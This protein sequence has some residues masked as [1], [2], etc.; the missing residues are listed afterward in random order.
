MRNPHATITVTAVPLHKRARA[1]A[2]AW[3][4]PSSHISPCWRA[5]PLCK[6]AVTPARHQIWRKG[7]RIP[8][9]SSDIP[10]SC[11]RRKKK[12]RNPGWDGREGVYKDPG[13]VG[14]PPPSPGH[15]SSA[16]FP[17]RQTEVSGLEEPRGGWRKY[18]SVGNW[19]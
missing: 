6:H 17:H 1:L 16:S 12:G 3:L 15:S 8:V 14:M 2:P 9:G 18:G 11:P 10:D 7:G 19:G 13:G 4:R 5:G